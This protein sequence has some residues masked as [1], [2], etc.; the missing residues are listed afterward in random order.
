[1]AGRPAWRRCDPDHLDGADAESFGA[2]MARLGDF[3]RRLSALGGSFVVAVG[4]GRFFR[5]Y[6]WA[7]T[8]NF[9]VAPQ[10]VREYRQVETAQPMANGEVIE[11]K[12][13]PEGPHDRRG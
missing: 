12:D 13:A 7:R 10:W 1:M 4:H 5:A 2:F 3:D 11:L 8:R 6:L 9:A